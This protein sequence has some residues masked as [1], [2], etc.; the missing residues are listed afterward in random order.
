MI[1]QDKNISILLI[2]DEEFDV[3]RVKKTVE[4][5]SEKMEIVHLFQMERLLSN[6][7]RR[8][9]TKLMW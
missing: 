6:I 9:G 3:R 1:F 7:L 2:E 5:F 4:P 8:T